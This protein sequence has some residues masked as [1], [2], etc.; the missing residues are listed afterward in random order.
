MSDKDLITKGYL[1]NNEVF[2]DL[3]NYYIYEGVQMIKPDTLHPLDTAVLANLYGKNKNVFH[4]QR[5][6][7]ILKYVSAMMDD[8]VTYLILAIE[9]QSEVHYAMPIRNMLY[10]ALQYQAQA[11]EIARKHKNNKDYQKE[12]KDGEKVNVGEF[13]SGF[14]KGDK[15]IPVITLVVNFSAD[16]WD[17]PI[18]IYDLLNVSNDNLYKYIPDYK[19]N[20]ISPYNMT[21]EEAN[22]FQ[23]D[24][25]EVMLYL[26]YSKDKQ[27]LEELLKR[28]ER[29]QNMKR[30]TAEMINAVTGS[31]IKF[32]TRKEKIDMCKAIQ[33]M[34]TDAR[35]N[36][37]EEGLKEG[38]ILGR[39]EQYIED[40]REYG[41]ND[42]MII[43]KLMEKFQMS[44]QEAISK[45]HQHD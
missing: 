19:I 25:R 8:K 20:L 12:S 36:G 41:A 10:D 22:R 14:Y 34:R 35:N 42:V 18:R 4:T 45:L 26:K 43:E 39:I 13:L 27:K 23:T 15:V 40:A 28:D 9:T 11:E 6:R 5:F 17:A 31:K 1:K 29:F 37:K 44:K 7:D 33:D 32:D 30:S 24:F 3:F 2:A 21:D 38:R 16:Q